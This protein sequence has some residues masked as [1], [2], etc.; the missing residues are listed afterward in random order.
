MPINSR[1]KGAT[2]ER[3]LAGELNALGMMAH[4][5]Q[6]YSG[7]MGDADLVVRGLELHVECKRVSRARIAEYVHQASHDAKG[8]PWAVFL[9]LDRQPWLVIQPLPQWAADSV[10]AQRAQKTR[11]DIVQRI[12]DEACPVSP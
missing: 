11:A 2:G 1:A 10:L 5:A 9:R 6:Q 7:A 8:K 4:R 12:V 3:E